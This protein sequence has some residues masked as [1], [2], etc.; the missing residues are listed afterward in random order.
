MEK[1]DKENM[2]SGYFSTILHNFTENE[3]YTKTTDLNL[4][5]RIIFLDPHSL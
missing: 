5:Q 1:S 2:L 3:I 4:Q